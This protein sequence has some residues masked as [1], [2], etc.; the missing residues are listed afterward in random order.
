MIQMQLAFVFGTMSLGYCV[1]LMKRYRMSWPT[2][3][4]IFM[5]G[6]A[7]LCIGLYAW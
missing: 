2:R 4:L 7:I 6:M 1:H 3:D 5:G